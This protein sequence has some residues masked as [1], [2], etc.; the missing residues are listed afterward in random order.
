MFSKEQSI[1]TAN[2][3]NNRWNS[4]LFFSTFYQDN[5][6]F[7]NGPCWLRN[8][9][10]ECTIWRSS[11]QWVSRTDNVHVPA[12]D[13]QIF[14]IFISDKLAIKP[15]YKHCAFEKKR[16]KAGSLSLHSSKRWLPFYWGPNMF[17][18][19]SSKVIS[20]PYHHPVSLCVLHP[21]RETGVL[22]VEV[23]S[24][25]TKSPSHG[26]PKVPLCFQY[27]FIPSTRG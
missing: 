17:P 19:N 22:K 16:S 10:T 5:N 3:N 12:I 14:R 8:P 15:H 9:P 20:Y 7:V 24:R 11:G 6:H 21:R 27:E 4:V 18:V 23:T 26:S 25:W 1:P 13:V 2:S